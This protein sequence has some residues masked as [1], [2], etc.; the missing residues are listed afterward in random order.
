MLRAVVSGL[1]VL[2]LA[3]VLTGCGVRGGLEYPEASRAET[4]TAATAASGQGKPE[5]AT[6]KP[7][8]GF[9]LDG[10]LQ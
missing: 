3:F 5:G 1:C 4:A 7:H 8:Q 10:L 6:A 9:I 2:G